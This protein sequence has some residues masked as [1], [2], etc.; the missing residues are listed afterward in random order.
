VFRGGTFNSIGADC[1]SAKRNS[2]GPSTAVNTIGFRVVLSG[3]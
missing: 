1:R 2:S 3:P